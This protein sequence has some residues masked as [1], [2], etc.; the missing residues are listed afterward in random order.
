M[1]QAGEASSRL[2]ATDFTTPVNKRARKRVQDFSP[3]GN[4]T[5]I[6][7]TDIGDSVIAQPQAGARAVPGIIPF[8]N[9]DVMNP[10][11]ESQARRHQ[12]PPF[13]EW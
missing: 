11:I 13:F 7:R 4:Q 2:T 9:T 10:N 5:R 3:I 8:D 6:T 12:R 1:M